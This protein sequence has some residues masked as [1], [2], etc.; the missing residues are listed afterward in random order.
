MK[1]PSIVTIAA[2]ALLAAV[3]VWPVRADSATDKIEKTQR[4]TLA[5]KTIQHARENLPKQV[6]TEN[7]E[8]TKLVHDLYS[9][10]TFDKPGNRRFPGCHTGSSRF[11]EQATSPTPNASCCGIP[12]LF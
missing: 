7:P 10:C 1:H 4:Y 9:D 6:S 2:A 11:P 5:E 8:L 3:A 12:C